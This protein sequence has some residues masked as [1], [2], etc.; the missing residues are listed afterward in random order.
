MTAILGFS[1]G[2]GVLM[3]ADT[4]ETTSSFTKSEADKL[5]RFLSQWGPVIT[6]GA[7]DSHFIDCAE[8]ELAQFLAVEAL[9][10]SEVEMRV[11]HP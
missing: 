3:M 5:S 7:G 6:G 8:Q 4:E 10:R 11:S 2:D 9:P 1:C